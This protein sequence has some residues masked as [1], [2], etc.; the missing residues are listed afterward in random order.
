MN[1]T[2]NELIDMYKNM[3][4]IRKFEEKVKEL[5]MEGKIF[6]LVHTCIGQEAVAVGSV[7]TLKEDDYIETTYRGHGHVIARGC[8]LGKMIAELMGKETGFCKGR[9]GSMHISCSELGILDANAIVG[10]GI[11]IAPGVALACKKRGKDQVVLCFF[12]DGASNQGMFHE[13]LNLSS[14]WKLPVV[15]ICENNLY[16]ETT[17]QK[18]HQAIKDISI[19]ANSY[20]IEGYSIDGNNVVA[21]YDEV[22]KAVNKARSGDGPTLIECKTYRFG[23][24][25]IG[26]PEVY[27]DKKEVEK[28]VKKDPILRFKEKLLRENILNKEKIKNID[29]LISKEI[30]EAVKFATDSPNPDPKDVLKFTYFEKEL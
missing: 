22:L 3:L 26:D 28:W 24:H 13:G 14:I 12:G 23:G 2:N 25:Y 15:F 19:R 29:N 27:R 30:D 7:K 6:G 9:G 16:G 8:D 17:P 18:R 11:V 20:G 4:K 10:A 1:L 5:F 21:V